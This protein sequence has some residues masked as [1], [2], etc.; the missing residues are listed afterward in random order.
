MTQQQWAYQLRDSQLSSPG[1][2]NIGGN[3]VAY[4]LAALPE[5]MRLS[6]P[7]TASSTNE[8]IIF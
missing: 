2:V 8:I 3:R 1:H 5:F 6:N 4:D 7:I